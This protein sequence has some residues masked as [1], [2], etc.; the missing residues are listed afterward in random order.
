MGLRFNMLLDD[1]RIKPADVRLLRHETQIRRG[2]TPY[3]LWRDDPAAF[4]RYQ[5]TQHTKNLAKLKGRY[6][7]GFVAP[8][9]GSTMFVGLYEVVACL[10]EDPDEP[11]CYRYDCRRV[12]LADAQGRDYEG[13]LFIHWGDSSSSMRAWVQRAD[14]QNKPIIEVRPKYQEEAFPGPLLFSS[15]LSELEALPPG[16]RQVL[17]TLTGVYALACTRT[18]ELYVGSAGGVDGFLGRWR[19]YAANGHGG[20]VGLRD[21][22]RSDYVVSILDTVGTR[23][24][25]DLLAME[26]AWKRKLLSVDL[27]LNRFVVRA[28]LKA[29][30]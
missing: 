11:G 4:E 19:G 18:G 27:G 13:R 6:W 3:L 24:A 14:N 25:G 22:E 30:S 26:D 12:P 23:D 29:G 8:S 15:R 28:P 2:V 21:R 10:G 17:T 9:P 20:N 5:G 1:A 16:W 7:A